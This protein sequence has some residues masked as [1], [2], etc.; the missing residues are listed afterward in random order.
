MNSPERGS[1][2]ALLSSTMARHIIPA[3]WFRC[4]WFPELFLK[5]LGETIIC[6]IDVIAYLSEARLAVA[7]QPGVG[8]ARFCDSRRPAGSLFLCYHV[9]HVCHPNASL[10]CGCAGP[11]PITPLLT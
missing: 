4:N 3:H 5:R 11:F 7:R 1:L 6:A 10:P 9:C 8:L 2:I